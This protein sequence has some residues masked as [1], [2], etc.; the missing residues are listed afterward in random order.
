MSSRPG[1]PEP[2]PELPLVPW[3]DDTPVPERDD[4]S[5]H[6]E[7]ETGDLLRQTSREQA[8]AERERAKAER[9]KAERAKA[10]R[11]TA[12][13]KEVASLEKELRLAREKELRLAKESEKST[14]HVGVPRAP[15]PRRGE[16]ADEENLQNQ[17]SPRFNQRPSFR[18]METKR[19]EVAEY[20]AQK[21]KDDTLAKIKKSIGPLTET[22]HLPHGLEAAEIRYGEIRFEENGRVVPYLII[23]E[24]KRDPEELLEAITA[25]KHTTSVAPFGAE[26]SKPT[27]IFAVRSGGETYLDWATRTTQD[28]PEASGG[29]HGSS[30]GVK[31]TEQLRAA[32]DEED[33]PADGFEARFAERVLDVTRT[34]ISCLQESNAWLFTAA[35]RGAAEQLIGHTIDR[36]RGSPEDLVWMQYASL[37][38]PELF[39]DNH[40]DVKEQLKHSSRPMVNGVVPPNLKVRAFYPS[41]RMHYPTA[42]HDSLRKQGASLKDLG[43]DIHPRA[44]HLLFFDTEGY[45]GPSTGPSWHSSSALGAEQQPHD[46]IDDLKAEMKRQGVSEGLILM[47][48]GQTEFAAAARMVSQLNPVIAMKNIGGASELM[49]HLFQTEVWERQGGRE[50]RWL[51]EEKRDVQQAQAELDWAMEQLRAVDARDLRF[52]GSAARLQWE[53]DKKRLRKAVR[54]AEHHV[55]KEQKEYEKKL[56]QEQREYDKKLKLKAQRSQHCNQTRDKQEKLGGIYDF[57]QQHDL[58]CIKDSMAESLHSQHFI[59]PDRAD[60]QEMVVIDPVPKNKS[61]H[62]RMQEQLANMRE[63]QVDTNERL[64]GF[65][66][67]EA[68]LMDQTW[69]DCTLFSENAAKQ[70]CCSDYLQLLT[71]S[72]NLMIVMAVV[73]KQF[74]YPDLSETPICAGDLRDTCCT[75]ETRT[76]AE[77]HVDATNQG[78]LW[79][80]ATRASL[81]PAVKMY[82]SWGWAVFHQHSNLKR[83]LIIMPIVNGVFLTI[84]SQLDPLTKW[85]ALAWADAALESETYIYRTRALHYSPGSSSDWQHRTKSARNDNKHSTSTKTLAARTY[86]LHNITVSFWVNCLTNS[87][88]QLPN[89]IV[90][91]TF[92]QIN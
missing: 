59:V 21:A 63:K 18:H 89:S 19:D 56:K 5:I 86:L 43:I 77:D 8:K 29:G 34:L 49:A 92:C 82:L 39:G 44:T 45:H 80:N 65:K 26:L 12:A 33:P 11:A 9:A 51:L 35:G 37:G 58:E 24:R 66:A 68:R 55:Q 20:R 38:N 17:F 28:E 78:Q 3:V 73:V 76:V 90:Q 81:L 2:E 67:L 50:R 40:D 91:L 57:E 10:E 52:G 48:G 41:Q 85:R 79:G 6:D 64:H 71:L 54:D 23:P 46:H 1:A 72:F 62:Q 61:V 75:T 53:E 84:L 27:A 47:N 36:F 87:I 13:R 83:L 70:K 22:I 7:Q 69:E 32:W 16:P 25:M 88:V 14:E 30:G 74:Y 60:V 31:G 15:A 42:G 4:P